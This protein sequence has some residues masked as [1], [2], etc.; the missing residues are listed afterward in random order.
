MTSTATLL[1]Y[2]AA[3]I[4]CKGVY[5]TPTQA[6]GLLP[7][8]LVCHAWDGLND[9]VRDK[10]AKLADAGYIAFALDVLGEGKTMTDMAD[11]IPTLT[12]F[13]ENRAMLLERLE[14]GVNAA[15]AIPGADLS[16]I[17][18]MGY[19]FG[20]TAVLDLARAGSGNIKGVVSFHGGLQG[21]ALNGPKTLSAKILVLHG[22]DDPL[23]P[24]EEVAA[25]K[26]EMTDKQADWQLHAYGQTVHAFTRPEANDPA[27][28]AV[29]NRSADARSWQA[30]LNFFEEV[31]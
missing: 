6:D 22:E 20:G 26:G 13:F 25:F 10:A 24:S 1:E 2:S 28:G 21:N 16:R 9:E 27:F 4:L 23:V 18:A 19:C 30:M 31:L 29:Y 17:G 14:A 15:K 12:P 3:D 7:V 11:L 5:F 8:V